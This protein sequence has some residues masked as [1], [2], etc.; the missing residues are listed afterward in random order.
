[1][2]KMI[3][4][5]LNKWTLIALSRGERTAKTCTLSSLYLAARSNPIGYGEKREA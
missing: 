1:M 4:A 5:C 2:W 3:A